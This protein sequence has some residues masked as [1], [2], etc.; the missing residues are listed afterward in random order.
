MPRMSCRSKGKPGV[1]WGVR[2]KCYTYTPGDSASLARAIARM[3]RQ[4]R[5]IKSAQARRRG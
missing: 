2:G 3:N 5:A 1:K 4:R